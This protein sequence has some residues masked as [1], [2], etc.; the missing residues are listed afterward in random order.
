MRFVLIHCALIAADSLSI[1]ACRMG[2]TTR[3]GPRG[4]TGTP[5]GNPRGAPGRRVP[6]GS[7]VDPT[8]G[9]VQLH[10]S[11]PPCCSQELQNTCHV[12]EV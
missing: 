2:Q 3:L 8:E 9:A 1:C 7:G 11:E 5:W 6:P 12:R 4:T 10:N